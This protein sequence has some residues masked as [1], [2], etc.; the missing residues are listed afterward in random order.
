MIPEEQLRRL[1]LQEGYPQEMV[2]KYCAWYYGPTGWEWCLDQIAAA[3]EALR[4]MVAANMED[5]LDELRDLEIIYLPKTT[6]PRPPR[7]A[8]PQNKG[9]A[10]NRQPP[11][12][13]RSCCRKMRR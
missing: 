10:W 7:Y 13:A 1:L 8:G 3:Y 12:L 11:R 4:Q 2:D 9:R 6:P 5:M